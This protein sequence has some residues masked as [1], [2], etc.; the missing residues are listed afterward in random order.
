MAHDICPW[1]VGYWL[2]SPIRKLLHNPASIL[3]PFVRAGM[4]VFEPGPGMGFFT[5]EM[6]RMAGPHGRIIAVDIQ[7]KMLSAIGRKAQRRGVRDRIELRL[8]DETGMGISD[9][10]GKVDFILAFAMVHELPDAGEFFKE[11]FAALKRGG[12]L[13][14][15]EPAHHIDISEF[16]KSL[17]QAKQAGFLVESMPTIRS[18]ISAVLVKK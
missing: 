9:L 8:A 5:L 16:A 3:T 10:S 17:D 18:N 12:K 7:P 4:T 2:A 14:F 1:W 11:S 15:S 6:A 13:L